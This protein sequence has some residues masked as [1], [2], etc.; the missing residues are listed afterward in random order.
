MI[1]FIFSKILFEVISDWKMS[2]I[3]TAYK[4]EKMVHPRIKFFE[5]VP[6]LALY[7]SFFLRIWVPQ[8]PVHLSKHG[9]T[10]D[11]G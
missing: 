9:K 7:A 10:C 3:F 5:P 6:Q 8:L 1:F 2:L 11:L 4:I